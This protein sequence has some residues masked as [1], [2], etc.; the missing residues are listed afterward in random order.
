MLP[1]VDIHLHVVCASDLGLRLL[2]EICR[3][4]G[5]RQTISSSVR[6]S[7]YCGIWRVLNG[8]DLW[9]SGLFLYVATNQYWS[10]FLGT[11][12]RPGLAFWIA[13]TDSLWCRMKRCAKT[14]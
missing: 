4:S 5:K 3:H 2:R 9:L 6:T 10:D 12:R 7:R 8:G 14:T 13:V 1:S 11:F